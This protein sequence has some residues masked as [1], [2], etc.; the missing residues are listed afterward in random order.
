MLFGPLA[1]AQEPP[2]PEPQAEQQQMPEA[3]GQQG[4]QLITGL[5]GQEYEPYKTS[6]IEDVQTALQSEGVY[7][8]QVNGV[9]DEATMQAVGEFQEQNGIHVSGVPSPKTREALGLGEGAQ[10]D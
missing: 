3:Q 6:V 1:F 5:D 7:S 4:G 8:G 2:Q 10:R 9:L